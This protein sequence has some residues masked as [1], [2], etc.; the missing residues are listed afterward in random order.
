MNHCVIKVRTVV[1]V[2]VTCWVYA[3]LNENLAQDI[4][5]IVIENF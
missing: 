1:Q 2:E 5:C 3:A 4:Y